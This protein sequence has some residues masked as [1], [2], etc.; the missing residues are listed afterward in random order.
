MVSVTQFSHQ[1]SLMF[2]EDHPS[3]HFLTTSAPLQQRYQ[4]HPKTGRFKC[5][6]KKKF[7]FYVNT[8]PEKDFYALLNPTLSKRNLGQYVSESDLIE[9]YLVYCWAVDFAH[10]HNMTEE[11]QGV[12]AEKMQEQICRKAKEHLEAIIQNH[13]S[14]WPASKTK[15]YLLLMKNV[16]ETISLEQKTLYYQQLIAQSTQKHFYHGNS[17]KDVF[18]QYKDAVDRYEYELLMQELSDAIQPILYYPKTIAQQNN[19]CDY[20]KHCFFIDIDT[21]EL[22]YVNTAGMVLSIPETSLLT[23]RV[24]QIKNMEEKSVIEYRDPTHPNQVSSF[25]VDRINSEEFGVALPVD[26][27]IMKS[28]IPSKLP[29]DPI[30]KLA[31]KTLK[32]T[33][34]YYQSLQQTL[35]LFNQET[36]LAQRHRMA[37]LI[38]IKEMLRSKP[39]C[40]I[41]QSKTKPKISDFMGRGRN[42]YVLYGDEQHPD[43]MQ[44]WLVDRSSD[45]PVLTQFPMT[46][47]Q[48]CSLRY[49]FMGAR[50]LANPV[51]WIDDADED[52]K[53][54]HIGVYAQRIRA[55]EQDKVVIRL[56][57]EQAKNIPK[58][59]LSDMSIYKHIIEDWDYYE[60]SNAL[61]DLLDKTKKTPEN[62]RLIERC[63]TIHEQLELIE[64]DRLH[65]FPNSR[66]VVPPALRLKMM[67]MMMKLVVDKDSPEARHYFRSKHL[68]Y[69]GSLQSENVDD[70]EPASFIWD[71]KQDKIIYLDE[72]KKKVD[73]SMTDSLRRKL[74]TLARRARS[75]QFSIS[76]DD[77]YDLMTRPRLFYYYY[78]VPISFDFSWLDFTYYVPYQL[79]RSKGLHTGTAQEMTRE[80]HEYKLS[81][82]S[83]LYKFGEVMIMLVI[84][85]ICVAN[86]ISFPYEVVFG[87]LGEVII[88]WIF[89]VW[90][91]EFTY[92]YIKYTLLM[93]DL[94]HPEL[95]QLDTMLQDLNQEVSNSSYANQSRFRDDGSDSHVDEPLS[96]YAYLSYL[97]NPPSNS[98]H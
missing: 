85:L 69:R 91:I 58:M 3:S 95:N 12:F 73:V 17:K 8:S 47:H 25:L 70:F 44:L 68:I 59:L 97:G 57:P 64:Q 33:K 53:W 67:Q 6:S 81:L 74:H 87:K 50:G 26:D 37:G 76:A 13:H 27:Q 78:G 15:L 40:E 48:A 19:I 52:D 9:Y 46:S 83:L 90:N 11:W 7:A 94:A 79:D 18:Y 28:L 29:K 38:Q 23:K 62:K 43:S 4:Y 24:H 45:I 31:E 20:A 54:Y 35:S 56:S 96:P 63:H 75:P 49:M 30:I 21:K 86:G 71:D 16:V 32:A 82:M 22:K 1:L 98:R 84:P 72:H 55:D 89:F 34:Q 42:T 80:I 39:T 41:M 93:N 36:I 61:I 5:K 2:A 60:T 66:G 51:G 92:Q 88:G 14:E 65:A 77:V 10:Q